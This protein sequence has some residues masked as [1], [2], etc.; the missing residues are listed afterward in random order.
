V[1]R[2]LRLPAY[3]YGNPGAYFV[4]ICTDRRICCLANINNG[5]TSVSQTG[6]IVCD[7]WMG[8]GKRFPTIQTDA[9]VVM[10]NHIHAVIILGT[11]LN[12]EDQASI[13]CGESRRSAGAI[14]RATTDDP[15]HL[16][17][18]DSGGAIEEPVVARFIAPASTNG[19]GVTSRRLPKLGAIVRD[20]KATST[21][22]IRA[23]GIKDF[24]WQPNYYEHIIRNGE[25]LD[26]IRRY[27]EGNPAN[28]AEDDENPDRQRR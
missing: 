23:A 7:A 25:S 26:R 3:D 20:F 24:G 13:K 17:S 21:Y 9:F 12:L 18:D 15:S 22:R 1:R 10:P 16:V 4:T 8:L 14:N 27:I 5:E 28:W 6:K 19:V 2:S 11:V